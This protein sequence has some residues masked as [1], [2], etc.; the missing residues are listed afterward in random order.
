[1]LLRASDTEKRWGEFAYSSLHAKCELWFDFYGSH[2]G[3]V[4]DV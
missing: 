4:Q 2:L 1:M 3:N